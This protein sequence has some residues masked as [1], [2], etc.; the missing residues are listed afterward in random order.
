MDEELRPLDEENEDNGLIE[1]VDEEGNSETFELLASFSMDDRQYLAVSDTTE[2]ED[3]ESVE[4]LFLRIEEDEEGNDVYVPVDDDA[5]SDA[6][7]A[8]FMDLVDA[9]E[10]GE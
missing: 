1:L 7:F 3:P 6:A 5:E 8:F 10:D 4:V 2:E 9:E